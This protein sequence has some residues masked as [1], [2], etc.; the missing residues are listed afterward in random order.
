MEE[1]SICFVHKD[2][3]MSS[4]PSDNQAWE[5]NVL[6]IPSDDDIPPQTGNPRIGPIVLATIVSEDRY[7]TSLLEKKEE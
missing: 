6:M 5:Q 4:P 7:S 2:P 3:Y 1:Y